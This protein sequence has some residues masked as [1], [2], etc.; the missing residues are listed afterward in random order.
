MPPRPNAPGDSPEIDV[1]PAQ[2]NDQ[3]DGEE[4]EAALLRQ[5]NVP[6]ANAYEMLGYEDED[7]EAEGNEGEREGDDEYEGE[8]ESD[9]GE[10]EPE[11]MAAFRTGVRVAAVRRFKKNRRP[12]PQNPERGG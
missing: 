7:D 6:G 5:F 8:G 9:D 10:D 11:D 4:S 2:G 3:E 12:R 1:V